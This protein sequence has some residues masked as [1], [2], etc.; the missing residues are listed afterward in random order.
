MA[1]KLSIKIDNDVYNIRDYRNHEDR[2]AQIKSKLTTIFD[3]IRVPVDRFF[4][5][6]YET[7]KVVI[8]NE[9]DIDK[10][11]GN[12]DK[13]NDKGFEARLSMA[14]RASLT[15][16]IAGYD[17]ALTQVYNADAIKQKLVDEGWKVMSVYVLQSKKAFKILM[18]NK[19]EVKKFLEME[20]VSI[21][22]IQIAKKNINKE[23]NPIIPQCWGCGQIRAGHNKDT[24]RNKVCL[25]CNSNAH[26]FTNCDIP[27]DPSKRNTGHKEKLY[28][29]PC[30]LRGDHTSLDHRACPTKR[31]IVRERIMECRKQ[32]EEE[33]ARLEKE[34][35]T[36]KKAFEYISSEF[37][38]LPQR[39]NNNIGHATLITLALLD[40]AV[41]PGCFQVKLDKACE[42]NNIEK[43][44]YKPEPE[45]AK[46]VFN[47]ICTPL[48]T[49]EQVQNITLQKDQVNTRSV[50][51]KTGNHTRWANDQRKRN[52]SEDEEDNAVEGAA[53]IAQAPIPVKQNQ[54]KKV[55]AQVETHNA[56]LN[57]LA[58]VA[59][60]DENWDKVKK[61]RENLAKNEVIFTDHTVLRGT[62]PASGRRTT[63][64]KELLD[65]ITSSKC[66]NN[67]E[68]KQEIINH[69]NGMIAQ[70]MG[71]Y[72]FTFNFITYPEN[73]FQMS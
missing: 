36:M 43:I 23:V 12:K 55:K 32:R 45:T 65:L 37:P 16:F 22:N 20:T 44:Q 2:A 66:N 41:N 51:T 18:K 58:N 53:A 47:A 8:R 1:V 3:N 27:K 4:A 31:G 14:L 56:K 46:A 24:C 50:K 9:A 38:Q 35:Q 52:N 7:I 60:Q 69:M 54:T 15:V 10:V 39:T 61:L 63:N 57:L 40:E 67:Q 71:E 30:G 68:W 26:D 25:K 29:V 34:K 13:F 62:P 33:E 11:F 19:E 5:P 72:Q 6:S 49:F 42:D 64:L 21:G 48:L 59:A 28:C 17:P 70:N 73:F